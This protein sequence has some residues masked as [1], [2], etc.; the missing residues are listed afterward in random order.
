MTR[1]TITLLIMA[2][3]CFSGCKGIGWSGLRPW[4]QPSEKT[5][6]G[7]HPLKQADEKVKKNDKNNLPWE[8]GYKKE[9][10]PDEPVKMFVTWTESEYTQAGK[11]AVRGFTARAY[12]YNKQY[13]PIEVDG[14]LI[15]YGF[16][17]TKRKDARRTADKKFVFPSDHLANQ[18]SR[19]HLGPS[20]SLWVP[21]DKVGGEQKH[22]SL[23]PVFRSSRGEIVRGEQ[24]VNILH[25]EKSEQD[26]D[27]LADDRGN[28]Q[29]GIRQVAFHDSLA[30][31][32]AGSEDARSAKADKA[33]SSST[34][35]SLRTTTIRV[36]PS[37]MRFLQAPIDPPTTLTPQPVSEPV[38]T[39]SRPVEDH[40][41]KSAHY[42]FDSSRAPI[43]PRDMWRSMPWQR[44]QASATRDTSP[45]RQ[46][47]DS[48]QRSTGEDQ[49][50]EATGQQPSV[51]SEPRKPQ[52]PARPPARPATGP[53][54]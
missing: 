5:E 32:S 10:E 7:R 39:V 20:Y 15:V 50:A 34:D 12:F 45:Q 22:I 44:A 28:D 1:I 4:Q 37:T 53:A 48:P 54:R 52:A 40:R 43:R 23:L 16:D 3:T 14:Q 51:R 47:A 24:I 11:P 29:G 8:F 26:Q 25:G 49:T 13:E 27:E 35:S 2:A 19:S 42:I 36:P 46:A 33:H 9:K 38:Q 18:F 21:W 41:E 6:H 30:S 31:E 17:D